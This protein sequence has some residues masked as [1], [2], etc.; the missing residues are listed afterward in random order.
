MKLGKL[1]LLVVLMAAVAAPCFAENQAYFY[2]WCSKQ[3]DGTTK[4]YTYVAIQTGSSPSVGPGGDVSAPVQTPLSGKSCVYAQQYSGLQP[5][6][7]Y[8]L[9]NPAVRN[10]GLHGSAQVSG[11][12][13][14]P[15]SSTSQLDTFGWL[16]PLPF[17]T[18]AMIPSS[19]T[20]GACDGSIH[21]YMVEH[22]VSRVE[23]LSACP[24]QSVKTFTPCQEPLEQ[25][26]TP[27]GSTLLVTCYDQKVVW[28]DTASNTIVYTLNA[29]GTYP[30]GVAISPD[31][32]KAYVT[33]YYDFDPS[34]SLL[35]IDMASRSIVQTIPLPSAFPGVV[36]LT[37][38]GSQAWVN[39]YLG[40]N[41]DV[42]DLLTGTVVGS[43][44]MDGDTENAIA[45][46]STGT[47]AF[48]SVIGADELAVVDTATLKVIARVHV[49][50]APAD[51]VYNPQEQTLLVGSSTQGLVSQ[52]NAVK[53][54]LIQNFNVDSGGIGLSLVLGK[55]PFQ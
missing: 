10:L 30:A 7:A 21:V 12:A 9:S 25:A 19:A 52:V 22:D 18:P 39:Y 49:A 44:L 50:P 55:L 45:F 36:A 5:L 8:P 35:V 46:N 2:Y 47:R 23:D 48:I 13:G 26:L 33:N 15:A 4:V 11:S 6:K 32:K 54:Q 37:P 14:A 29:P 38:D 20:S 43:I 17:D 40:N 41:V 42:V 51:V 16:V 1:S 3:L 31:G 24:L 34:P 53:N 28:I 27:D